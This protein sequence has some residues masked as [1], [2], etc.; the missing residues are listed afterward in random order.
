MPKEKSSDP[1]PA[2]IKVHGGPE[3]QARP[4]YDPVVQYLV[5]R[6]FAVYEPN[7]RGSTG[8]GRRYAALDDKRLRFDAVKDLAEA[9]TFLGNGG[10]VDGD[11]I[12]LLGG[13]YG[14]F[15]VLAGI[16][17]FPDLWRSA[18]DIVGIANFKTFLEET[19]PYRRKWREAEYGTIEEDGDFLD[20]ISPVHHADRIRAPLLVIQ[21]ANDPRVPQAEAEQIVAAVRA[22][23]GHADYR[24][25]DDEGHG[26]VKLPNR[27]DA[28]EAI[29]EFLLEH[30]A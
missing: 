14:G 7:V 27:I 10:R 17:F 26:I 30:G 1:R 19:G 3:S 16:A 18:V 23:G 8:Y 12:S 11:R 13:S 5:H 15:M 4:W 2:V 25:Y 24:L 9:A 22:N 20:E 21:G 6:G 28:Y 29:V